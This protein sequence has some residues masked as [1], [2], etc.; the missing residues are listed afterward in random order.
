MEQE[1]Q[2]LMP[3]FLRT[4]SCINEEFKNQETDKITAPS[5]EEKDKVTNS[6]SG[7]YPTWLPQIEQ[8]RRGLKL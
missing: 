6:R 4:M 1:H 2:F 8:E 5:L 7:K 3:V